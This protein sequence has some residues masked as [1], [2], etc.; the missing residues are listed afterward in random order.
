MKKL[1]LYILAA[2]FVLAGFYFYI[3]SPYSIAVIQ[4]YTDSENT[5]FVV[6]T[7][8][9]DVTCEAYEEDL[10]KSISPIREENIIYKNPEEIV[11]H[12]DFEKLSPNKKYKLLIKKNSQTLTQRY[13][14]MLDTEKESFTVA[15]ESCTSD[16]VHLPLLWD[17]LK[18]HKPDYLFML[19]DNVYADIF[20][21]YVEI[22]EDHLW[23]R[24]FR[25][26]R[27]FKV[28]QQEEL[29]PVLAI[30]DDHDYGK[31]NSDSSYEKKDFTL[32]LFR[33]FFNQNK[34]TSF[35]KQGPGT[36]FAFTIK[37]QHF[38]FLDA[39]SF[40]SPNN[41]REGTYFSDEQVK[42]VKEQFSLH[43]EDHFWLISGSQW[44]GTADQDE[45]FE[46]NHPENVYRFIDDIG[47]T[48]YNVQLISG[49]SHFSEIKK[50][51]LPEKTIYEITSSA[52][53]A[54]PVGKISQDARRLSATNLPNFIIGKWSLKKSQP[55]T[56][57]S[58]T[59]FNTKLFEHSVP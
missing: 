39:R 23:N 56:F 25:S 30:W 34:N 1:F 27:V 47:I 29:T 14:H 46:V 5:H 19:G 24:Y 9:K 43:P 8:E 33:T 31:N 53:H 40:R 22:T 38:I 12:C 41:S 3:I 21:D 20:K 16:I 35:L 26:L 55:S 48:K 4:G 28:F 10:Q 44:F 13:F 15:L 45:S 52:M 18:S 17:N 49:D 32:F 51:P 11:H 36:S 37:K 50:I 54:L 42:W 2:I 7:T 6:I 57:S 58:Y 59:L